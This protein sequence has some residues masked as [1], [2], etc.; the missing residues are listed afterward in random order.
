MKQTAPIVQM[1]KRAKWTSAD[2]QS[3]CSVTRMTVYNWRTGVSIPKTQDIAHM[4]AAL[5]KQGIKAQFGDFIPK[6]RNAA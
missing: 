3:I 1:M 4:L 6:E 2:V 5:N